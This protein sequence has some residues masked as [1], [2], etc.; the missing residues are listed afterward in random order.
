MNKYI[1]HFD[2]FLFMK[3]KFNQLLLSFNYDKTRAILE[4][5]QLAVYMTLPPNFKNI[6]TSKGANSNDDAKI[7]SICI[8][9]IQ[10]AEKYHKNYA[11]LK[12]E[13]DAFQ[14]TLTEYKY[15]TS[16]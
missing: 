6:Y 13:D 11:I 4:A 10:F 15:D 2:L 9:E 12:H 8:K 3:D 14:K 1:K 5:Y 16:N 7:K